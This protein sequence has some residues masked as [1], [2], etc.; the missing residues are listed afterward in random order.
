MDRAVSYFTVRVEK[1]RRVPTWN[2]R[3]ETTGFTTVHD[4]YE[5]RRVSVEV[6]LATLAQRFGERACRAKL[7]KATAAGG[8]VVVREIR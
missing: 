6:D 3:G 8:C 2:A 5:E 1:R 7:R 4:G